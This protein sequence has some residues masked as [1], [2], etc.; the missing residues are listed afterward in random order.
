MDKLHQRD[1]VIGIASESEENRPAPGQQTWERVANFLSR[2]WYI[3]VAGWMC[4]VIVSLAGYSRQK[5]L[6][7]DEI[8]FRFI[9][10]Q[11][12]LRAVWHAQT[13]GA[14]SD[15]P[16]AQMVTHGLISLFGSGPLIVRLPAIAGLAVLMLFLALTVRRHAGGLYALVALV[17]PFCTLLRD[18]GYEARSYGLMYG[19]IGLAIYCW[20]RAGED[21]R[22]GGWWNAGFGVALAGAF[23]C[24]FY[25]VFVLPGFLL[26][27]AVRTLRR[28]RISWPT[29]AAMVGAF[30]T[31]IFYLPII[32]T[33]R[34]LSGSYFEKPS[35]RSV[36][37]TVLR[38]LSGLTVPLFVFLCIASLL[39]AL[40]FRFARDTDS[41]EVSCF[42]ESVALALGLMMIPVMGWLAGELLL[43]AF[44]DR[45]VLHGVIGV[46]LLIPLFAAQ[47]FRRDRALG[48][49][50][51][52]AFGLWA[53]SEAGAGARGVLRP[54]PDNPDF[55]QIAAALPEL[56]GDIVVSSP[57]IFTQMITYSPALKD[58]CILLYD[59]PKELQFT[60]QDT[61][62][63]NYVAAR[64]LGFFRTEEWDRYPGRDGSFLFLTVPDYNPDWP[65]W[66][67]DYLKSVN[68]YGRVV[69]TFGPYILVEAKPL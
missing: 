25:G 45:Y 3:A 24:H 59:R 47:V 22:D 26:G 1:A 4:A 39:I 33:A 17:L 63:P 54:A 66:L 62:T 41:N 69:R 23:A 58:R 37:G 18:Y 43:K 56:P 7:N 9:A 61:G 67:R 5:P 28:R 60:G 40:G 57:H 19:L 11:P 42:R 44:T 21:R 10:L 46:C 34:K 52:L 15:P 29:V 2:Y 35:L 31:L 8:F 6:W 65:G 16:L 55:V 20:T 36:P 68:R 50:L 64:E 49:A 30:A 14:S 32:V 12:S 13:I 48:L 27:E 38:G 53:V 51:V